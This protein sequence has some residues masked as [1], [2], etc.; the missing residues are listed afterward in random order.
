MQFIRVCVL[1]LVK[2]VNSYTAV[3][4]SSMREGKWYVKVLK[5]ECRDLFQNT[6]KNYGTDSL[7]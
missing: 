7:T 6:M 4:Y 5:G 2:G 1:R 3:I